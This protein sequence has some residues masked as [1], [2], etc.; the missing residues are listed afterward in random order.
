MILGRSI[1]DIEKNALKREVGDLADPSP[2]PGVPSAVIG[3]T[4]FEIA[5]VLWDEGINCLV[6]AA[7]G[8]ENPSTWYDRV[9]EKLPAIDTLGR[10]WNHLNRGGKAILGVPSLRVPGGLH[11]IVADG[12][13][14]LDP[15][16]AGQAKRVYTCLADFST[17]NPLLIHEAI[18][19][20]R[21][22]Q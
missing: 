9:G 16:G 18:L 4:S 14:F 6:V 3:V 20:R 13:D 12:T 11:W 1:E 22:S 19:I 5:C 17:D 21:E 15:R 10:T 7:S 8:S 2:P